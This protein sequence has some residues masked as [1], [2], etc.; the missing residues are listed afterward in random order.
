M[1]TQKKQ[2]QNPIIP[3]GHIIGWWQNKSLSHDKGGSFDVELYL[4]LSKIKATAT[5]HRLCRHSDTI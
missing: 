4:K 5:I 1:R 2:K 3:I